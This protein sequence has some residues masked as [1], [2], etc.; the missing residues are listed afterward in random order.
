MRIVTMAEKREKT[1][2]EMRRSGKVAQWNE[3]FAGI[4]EG[5]QRRRRVKA[6]G[7]SGMEG[8]SEWQRRRLRDP[9]PSDPFRQ[10]L[11]LLDL[12]QLVGMG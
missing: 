8:Q 12:A 6:V 9:H 1:S 3:E 2:A 4:E 11:C 10:R 7:R 5:E